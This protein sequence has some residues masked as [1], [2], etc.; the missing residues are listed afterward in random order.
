MLE[1]ELR[2]IDRPPTPLGQ[3][4]ITIFALFSADGTTVPQVDDR[5]ICPLASIANQSSPAHQHVSGDPGLIEAYL[6]HCAEKGDG[7]FWTWLEL[8]KYLSGDSRRGG[9]H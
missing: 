9:A 8:H 3:S 1:L 2:G 5:L 7:T 6:R 4:W